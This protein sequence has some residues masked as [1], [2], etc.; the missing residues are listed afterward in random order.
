[1][2]SVSKIAIN[3]NLP[4]SFIGSEKIIASL[5]EYSNKIK[6]N[7]TIN[8]TTIDIDSEKVSFIKQLNPATLLIVIFAHESS[9]SYDEYGINIIRE[10]Q[11]IENYMNF[12]VIIPEQ[13]AMET[14]PHSTEISV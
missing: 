12:I 11:R 13:Y 1:M 10:L 7:I 9:I 2:H 14:L 8:Y 6:S 3:T 4:I 5:K